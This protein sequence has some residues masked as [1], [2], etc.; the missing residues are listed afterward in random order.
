[1]SSWL[2]AGKLSDDIFDELEDYIGRRL[3]HDKNKKTLTREILS[4]AQN[5]A[6]NMHVGFMATE[7]EDEKNS[8]PS[9]V[10]AV[11]TY[12]MSNSLEELIVNSNAS[13]NRLAA[14]VLDGTK[15]HTAGFSKN[16][17]ELHKF[18]VRVA[19][20]E[21]A[22]LCV[23]IEGLDVLLLKAVR[24]DVGNVSRQISRIFESIGS[25]DNE[26][27][28]GGHYFEA[29]YQNEISLFCQKVQLVG[30]RVEH[31]YSNYSLDSSYV[32]L[33]LRGAKGKT[34]DTSIAEIMHSND[35]VLILGSGGSGKTTL[36][37]WL[38][39]Q[40]ARSIGLGAEGY[41][42]DHIP[43][44]VQLRNFDLAK[45]DVEAFVE[46]FA[47]VLMAYKRKMFVS[48]TMREG[49]A[50]LVLDGVDEVTADQRALVFDLVAK[51]SRSFP[52]VKIVVTARQE[53]IDPDWLEQLDFKSFEICT[54]NHDQNRLLIARWF[55]SVSEN[56]VTDLEKESLERFRHRL[57][58]EFEGSP[59]LRR[60]MST[61]LLCAMI[62]SQ[63]CEENGYIP[64]NRAEL[65]GKAIG[66]MVETR[67]RR[68]FA[69]SGHEHEVIPSSDL[70][71]ILSSIAF[72]TLSA[73]RLIFSSNEIRRIAQSTLNRMPLLRKDVNLDGLTRQ[74]VE[75]SGVIIRIGVANY[76]FSHKS[77]Q[78]YLCAKYASD[79]G[80]AGTIVG[81]L[82]SDQWRSVV[83]FSCGISNAAMT[84]EV[85]E[86]LC[87]VANSDLRMKFLLLECYEASNVVDEDTEQRIRAQL[88]DVVPPTTNEQEVIIAGLGDSIV[89]QLRDLAVNGGS[90]ALP[91]ISTLAR[92]GSSVAMEALGIVAENGED[93]I[94]DALL[95]AWPSFDQVAYS[96]AVCSKMSYS[97]GLSWK[98]HASISGIRNLRFLSKLE[99]ADCSY[100]ELSEVSHLENLICLSVENCAHLNSLEFLGKLEILEELRLNFTPMVNDFGQ[101][102]RLKYLRT[103]A[104]DNC[105]GAT[106]MRFLAE[107]ENLISLSLEGVA[108]E[109]HI[110]FLISECSA[111]EYDLTDC[112]LVEKIDG[113]CTFERRNGYDIACVEVEGKRFFER[114]YSSPSAID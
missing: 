100:S 96:N 53:A 58:N 98:K 54:L 17:L 84:K 95:A 77:V 88:D 30:F 12:F 51:I 16:E 87:K 97:G 60:L 45:S 48:E 61:P 92:I 113:R 24:E 110:D 111:V 26:K 28:V 55:E 31:K 99:V 75:R 27:I 59:S 79:Q 69:L 44:V 89:P 106:D 40:T 81:R 76:S 5:I 83:A 29:Q 67:D 14:M 2:N 103:L 9:I 109:K 71:T 23:E 104:I 6:D 56:L 64:K 1:M 39:G 52:K 70:M 33:S 80:Y 114:I 35:R 86:A 32:R 85:L 36:S 65:F 49:K 19:S 34:E 47:S 10:S 91:C 108:T 105:R 93:A 37:R 112:D 107:C 20:R 94:Q 74:I 50:L 7:F 72:D 22:A 4:H 18:V 38:A 82:E 21:A 90:D 15:Y 63:V 8:L 41:L 42:A 62:C 78:E 57:I 11:S 46:P 43:F 3:N 13:P 73:G 68:R 25:R 101:I 102:G 66:A